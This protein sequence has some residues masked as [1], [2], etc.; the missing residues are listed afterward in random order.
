MSISEHRE[1]TFGIIDSLKITRG[2]KIPNS[3]LSGAHGDIDTRLLHD[4]GARVDNP[5]E[6]DGVGESFWPE[7]TEPPEVYRPSFNLHSS[8]DDPPPPPD[9]GTVDH[10]SNS[11]APAPDT[12]ISTFP[13]EGIGD[14]EISS[15][16]TV[17]HTAPVP[18]PVFG[19]DTSSGDDQTVVGKSSVD[20][21]EQHPTPDFGHQLWSPGKVIRNHRKT[22]K[23]VSENLYPSAAPVTQQATVTELYKE[24]MMALARNRGLDP[25]Q[26]A[27]YVQQLIESK[28]GPQPG[29]F[30][31]DED[32]PVYTEETRWVGTPDFIEEP[33]SEKEEDPDTDRFIG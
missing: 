23:D 4:I 31:G 22:H 13:V 19:I 29:E 14:I 10:L 30:L 12:V 6:S 26:A 27:H 1:R 11:D 16:G 28:D 18:E 9:P 2:A 8:E 7:T 24:S 3:G 5:D 20:S 32:K 17:R 15:D 25:E 21:E 33:T